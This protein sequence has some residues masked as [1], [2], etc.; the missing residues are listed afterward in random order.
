MKNWLLPSILALLVWGLWA[1]LPK[2][3]ARHIDLQ[4]A[5]IYQA[6]GSIL[7]GLGMLAAMKFNVQYN[8]PG[9]TSGMAIGILGIFGA[10]LYLIAVSRGPLTLVAPITGLYPLIAI[11]L[12]L[13]FLKESISLKQSIGIVFSLAAI[14]LISA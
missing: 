3:T 13:V 1:F 9:F 12:G 14:Y 7:F 10:Y 11:I 5:L 8:L 2:I 6:F 4:S